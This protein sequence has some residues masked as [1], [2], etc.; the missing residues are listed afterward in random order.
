MSDHP[1]GRSS[2][3]LNWRV[4]LPDPGDQSLRALG[5]HYDQKI[6]AKSWSGT[7]GYSLTDLTRPAL[8]EF[9]HEATRLQ[10]G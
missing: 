10:R 8:S 7:W 1:N 3:D 6:A 2:C 9:T 4:A 5:V